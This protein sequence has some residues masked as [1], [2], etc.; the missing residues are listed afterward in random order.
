MTKFIDI[1]NT[2]ENNIET[3]KTISKDFVNPFLSIDTSTDETPIEK[4]LKQSKEQALAEYKSLN[5]E[6]VKSLSDS[7]LVDLRLRAG[8]DKPKKKSWYSGIMAGTG[9]LM[10]TVEGAFQLLKPEEERTETRFGELAKITKSTWTDAE[11]TAELG[12]FDFGDLKNPDFWSQKALRT[13]PITLSLIPMA[14]LG[15]EAA[16]A[17][18]GAAKLGALGTTIAGTYKLGKIAT[19]ISG[20]IG[21]TIA[22]RPVESLMEASGAYDEAIAKGMSGDEARAVSNEVF[23]KNITQMS[24]FD[25]VQMIPFIKNIKGLS[26][27]NKVL[28]KAIS[29]VGAA[30]GIGTEGVEEVLQNKIVTEALGEEFDAMSPESQEA[31]LLGIVSGGV[32]QGA[33]GAVNLTQKAINKSAQDK[34]D[35]ETEEEYL[36]YFEEHKA[37]LDEQNEDKTVDNSGQA[38]LLA[39]NDVA[40]TNQEEINRVIQEVVNEKIEEVRAVN[41]GT[42]SEQYT[43]TEQGLEMSIE[44]PLTYNVE[45]K[46]IEEPTVIE[47]P[48]MQGL[49]FTQKKE[50]ELYKKSMTGSQQQSVLKGVG[51]KYSAYKRAIEG[52]PTAIEIKNEKE[53]L[54]KNYV[55]KEVELKTGESVIVTGTAYGKIRVKYPDGTIKSVLKSDI[56]QKDITRQ[57]VLSSLKDKAIKELE[58]G[59]YGKD[60]IKTRKDA[61]LKSKTITELEKDLSEVYVENKD[62]VEKA[63]A[64]IITE[65][66]VSEAGERLAYTTEENELQFLSK[67][68][69][70]PKWIDE[71]L[72][73]KKL[74]DKVM[75]KLYDIENIKYP[76]KNKIN[77]RALY[78]TILDEVDSR[79]RINTKDIRDNIIQKYEE[80]TNKSGKISVQKET[81][82]PISE[83]NAGG[84]GFRREI[85]TAI[86]EEAKTSETIKGVDT[87]L[88]KEAIKY[89]SAEE[90]V[91]SQNLYHGTPNKIKGGKL[92]YGMK[93]GQDSGGLFF[94]DKPEVANTFTFGKGE[95]YQATPEIK[96][97][98]IDLTKIDGIKKVESY[99]GK[100]YKTFDGETVKFTKQDFDIMFPNGKTD[101]ASVSQYPELIQ[102]IVKD[103]GKKGIAFEEYAGGNTGKTYQIL[104]GDVPV[105]TKSQLTDIWNKAQG[106]IKTT[107]KATDK[108]LETK[109]N[110]EMV[111]S[112][113]GVPTKVALSM[114]A[115]SIE[116]DLKVEFKTLAEYDATTIKE[117]SR[118]ISNI[119]K[120]NIERAKRIALGK[121]ELPAGLKGATVISEMEK[122]AM[123][124]KDGELMLELANS[125]LVTATSEAGQTMRL[126]QERDPDSATAQIK[127]IQKALKEASK[128][129]MKGKTATEI[130]EELN[131]AFQDKLDKTKITKEEFDSFINDIIC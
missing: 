114:E 65:M 110:N 74:F 6:Q 17:A 1:F 82:K 58:Q 73:S 112:T 131:K 71:K 129:K 56:Q 98:V 14:I 25:V 111:E 32:F 42:T 125:K 7:E 121:E 101:F 18:T 107:T 105:Y 83:S 100:T 128:V 54:N 20:V 45:T 130:K 43:T 104:E 3:K 57:E 26:I 86:K 22:S 84:E 30:L 103:D 119:M 52:N 33:G 60:F 27:D 39:F 78:D 38:G 70:F 51:Y 102:K 36:K 13:L 126:I 34:L 95:V 21:G 40:E 66:D 85:I 90:F 23:E 76:A 61:E 28:D 106:V 89:K 88:A 11:T 79:A 72:R 77:Q 48:E 117:Q 50:V 16:I 44:E 96:N 108:L 127:E 49:R 63:L 15:G 80:S 75:D 109:P 12:E 123:R 116:A 69:T 55:N 113:K 87:K 47:S 122:Y 2:G 92:T 115:K 120:T 94:T 29:I 64:E 62:N 59:V 35:K 99:I 46:T 9:D 81:K 68:S 8:L 53:R 19:A 5:Y 97:S 124:T 37:E 24:V 118:L 93:S 10:S 91:N 4:Q 67:P 31:L 41:G